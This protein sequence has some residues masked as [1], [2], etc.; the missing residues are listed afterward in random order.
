[1]KIP[2]ELIRGYAAIGF[3][4]FFALQAELLNRSWQVRGSGPMDFY[5]AWAMLLAF[6]G[7]LAAMAYAM[8][9][10]IPAF[11]RVFRRIIRRRSSA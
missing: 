5:F 4:V 11:F 1:M 2:K 3:E 9:Q 8:W 6:F 7:M 10:F